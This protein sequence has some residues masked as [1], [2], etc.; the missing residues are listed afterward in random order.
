MGKLPL[1][2]NLNPIAVIVFA[3]VANGLIL[4]VASVFLLVILNNRNK[5]GPYANTWKQNILGGLVILL[6]SFLGVWN[7]LRLFLH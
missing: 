3:Q 4:P 5:M 1:L 6:V 2:F 7:I